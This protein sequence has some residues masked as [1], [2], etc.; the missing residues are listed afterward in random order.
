MPRFVAKL[1]GFGWPSVFDT[2]ERR[3]VARSA[4]MAAAE[5]LAQRM[6]QRGSAPVRDNSLPAQLAIENYTDE[7]G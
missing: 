2:V 4:D 1:D 3:Y 6:N 5:A 7:A